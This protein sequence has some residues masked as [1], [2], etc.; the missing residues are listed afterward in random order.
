M[1]KMKH[2][3]IVIT[4]L[5]ST[6]FLYADPIY[7]LKLELSQSRVSLSMWDHV[8][9]AGNTC[10]FEFPTDKAT[11]DS[12]NIGDNILNKTRLGSLIVRGSFSSWRIKVVGKR[13]K[14]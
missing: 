8:K 13:I 10:T 3:I 2:I 12:L 9:D 11:Y 4:L 7:V 1:N 14:K 5:L 6:S